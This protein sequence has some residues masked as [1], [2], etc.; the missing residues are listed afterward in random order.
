M[1]P[2]LLTPETTTRSRAAAF[3]LVELLVVVAIIAL[4]IAILLPSLNRARA[5]SK[6]TICGSNLR[7]V[8][9]GVHLYAQQNGDAIPRGPAE[10]MPFAAQN[11][12]EW[13]TNQVWIGGKRAPLGLGAL[14]QHDLTQPKV[15][16]CPADDTNDPSEELEKIVRQPDEDAFCSYL[17][18][19]RDQTTRD[20]LDHLG[21]N[22]LK[23]PAR[24]LAL[25]ANSLG[26]GD[27]TRTNHDARRV[28]ILYLEGHVLRFENRENVLSI[29]EQ[30]YYGFPDSMER[31]LNEIM[32][33]ADYAE[34]DDPAR[35]PPLP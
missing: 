30:D 6:L 19:Q 1:N 23:F 10:Q 31:R 20:R 14:I 25:D 15:L 5:Q 13:A 2:S 27:F 24:A 26:P 7:Q 16:Y 28:N 3:T 21:F 33:A 17:Y 32:V 9:T 34:R 11:W 22:D 8:G 29:R 18:R 12:D 4:L 35:T